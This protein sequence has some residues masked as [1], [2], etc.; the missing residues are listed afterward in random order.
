MDKTKLSRREM[1]SAAKKVLKKHY[2][3]LVVLCL[4]LSFFNVEFASSMD[5]IELSSD[6]QDVVEITEGE[7]TVDEQASKFGVDAG[8]GFYDFVNAAAENGLPETIQAIQERE[9]NLRE[10]TDKNSAF[11]TTNGVLAGMVD[12]FSTGHIWVVLLK[13]VTNFS[14]D[15]EFSLLIMMFVS[16][17]LVVFF[18]FWVE[19]IMI[20][21]ERRFFLEARTYDKLVLGRFNYIFRIRCWWKVVKIM[22]LC[23]IYKG[24]WNLTIIGGVIKSYSYK[25]VPFIAAENPQMKPNEVI[26][27]SRKMMDGHK[28]EFFVL[29]L[30]F[31]GWQLLG[32]LTYHVLDIFFVNPY[33]VSTYSEY[34]AA[35]RDEAK[36]LG[37]ENADKLNDRYLYEKAGEGAIRQ[38]YGDVIE[39]LAKEIPEPAPL[40]GIPGILAN[41]FGVINRNTPEERAFEEAEIHEQKYRSLA[42]EVRGEVYPGRLFPVPV[43][44]RRETGSN[45]SYR[46][47][48]T[49]SSLVAMFFIFAMFGWFWEVT[50]HFITHHEFVNRGTLHGPW[51]PI[52]GMGAMIVLTLLYRVRSKPWLLTIL[53]VVLCGV[54]EYFSGWYCEVFKGRSYWNYQ[55]YFLNLHGRICAEGLM[56][57]AL[58]G[59]AVTYAIGPYLDDLIRRIPIK[60]IVPILAVFVVCFMGD[61]IY[62]KGHPNTNTGETSNNA[63][64][65]KE[66]SQAAPA[67]AAFAGIGGLPAYINT[68]V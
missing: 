35:Y 5:I 62:T 20:V 28:W 55:G 41:W 38:A 7:T 3:I 54:L 56:V 13:T 61:Q 66:G 16:L 8:A 46:R 64:R 51:L 53:T 4:I 58:A 30:S 12:N 31:I 22:G 32:L 14:G 1:K 19:N 33:I 6:A 2:W 34:Y 45:V 10:T 43:K 36:R 49:V 39:E 26:T 47:H 57:F 21:I 23:F 24:L 67:A 63:D 40:K 25:M 42:E 44:K 29:D 52:Y 59:V 50:L 17:T 15:N 11:G 27:L 65:N 68:G 60:V 18:L 37:I 48:Y 9:Q